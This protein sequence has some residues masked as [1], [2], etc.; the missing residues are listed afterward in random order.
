MTTT[1]HA[2]APLAHRRLVDDVLW[3]RL[4]ARVRTDLEFQA[5][6]DESAETEQISWSER[7]VD[8]M[9]AY[10]ALCATTR[11]SYA[12]APLVD[13]GWHA[14]LV[15]TREYA[16]F[17][18][19]ISGRFIHHTPYDVP[20]VDYDLAATDVAATVAALHD[21]GGV[22]DFELWAHASQV[23]GACAGIAGSCG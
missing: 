21:A 17:C 19:R 15:Y 13:I 1:L 6:F 7:I 10:L 2:P 14:F 4:T 20:G 9:L 23:A 16:D 18:E 5:V 3:A 12:M 22:V 8:A 11:D